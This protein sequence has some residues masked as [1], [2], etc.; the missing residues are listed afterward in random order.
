[1]EPVTAVEGKPASATLKRNA[2][3]AGA[4][5]FL[6]IAMAAPL[7]TAS[8]NFALGMAIGNGIGL[9][10]TYLIIA[11]VLLVFS[12]GFAAMA[13]QVVNTGAFYAYVGVALGY[14]MG[15]AAG[16]MA[17]IGYNVLS[18]FGFGVAGFFATQAFTTVTGIGV[19]WWIGSAV[20]LVVSFLLGY[21]GVEL[22]T[23]VTGTLLV[24]ECLF[25]LVVDIA[26]L[27]VRGPAAF[28]LEVFNPANIFTGGFGIA[29]ALAFL[30]FIGF[31]ATAIFSEEA[32][33]PR[34]TVG[35]ATRIALVIIGGLYVISSWAIVANFGVANAAEVAA[36][37]DASA[38]FITSITDALGKTGQIVFS[39]LLVTSFLA[40]TNTV[41]ATGAR[42]IFA[43]A[44]ARLLPTGLGVVEAKHGSPLR[45]QVVQAS[46]VLVILIVWASINLDPFIDLGVLGTLGSVS[47]IALQAFASF[48]IF[49]YFRKRKDPRIWRTAIAPGV[50]TLLLLGVLVVAVVAWPVLIGFGSGPLLVVPAIIPIVGIVGWLVAHRRG[51][52]A[53][54]FETT[55]RADEEPATVTS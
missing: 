45:A 7:A 38:M 47:I 27:A 53:H 35:R 20:F 51:P 44:R 30:S 15:A 5:A 52:I 43:M 50:A 8:G 18:G 26:I 55:S 48:A 54:E 23:R 11:L 13:R 2:L 46:I 31:E 12:V 36:G 14:R 37:P 39:V 16:Y 3:G 33:D 25:L 41:H 6:V 4:I 49:V 9:P 21:G 22:S 42:Y 19:P 32:K 10:G 34:R 40:L 29:I 24:I 28:S 1:M 17:T